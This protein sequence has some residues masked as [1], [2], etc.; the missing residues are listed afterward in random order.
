MDTQGWFSLGL[1]VFDL[2]AVQGT[3]TSLLQDHNLKASVLQHSVF[4]MVQ[5]SYLYMNTEKIIW[6][7]YMDFCWQSNVSSFQHT[8]QICYSFPFKEHVLFN[9]MAVLT[10]CSD[11]ESKEIKS[12]TAS[13]FLPSICHEEMGPDAMIL[14]FWKLNF[15]PAFPLSSFPFIERLLSSSSFSAI[16]VVSSTYL[17]LLTFHLEIW[18]PTCDSSSLAFCMMF[19]V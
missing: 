9:F 1:T 15:K 10:V 5:L 13:T 12:V 18:I 3:L 19:S 4:F 7:D 2:L 16:R 14:V 17:R 8:V 11:L 6:T